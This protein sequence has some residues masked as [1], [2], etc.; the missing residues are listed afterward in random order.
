MHG[1]ITSLRFI[2]SDSIL[3]PRTF[4]LA[5][6][7]CRGLFIKFDGVAAT[8]QTP[9]MADFGVIDLNCP[10]PIGHID[11]AELHKV[12]SLTYGV[13]FSSF[14]TGA[15]SFAAFYIPF[16]N[17]LD[18]H[19]HNCFLL[20]KDYYMYI[21]AL[22]NLTKW[23]SCNVF[24]YA[25]IVE[26]GT[27]KYTPLIYSKV[28]GLQT[29]TKIYMDDRNIN[30]IA[31]SKPPTAP[32]GKIVLNRDGSM[33][34]DA[35]WQSSEILTNMLAEIE[36]GTQNMIL[37]KPYKDQTE[38]VGHYYELEITGCTAQQEFKFMVFSMLF[39]PQKSALAI[40]SI[41][42]Q[43]QRRFRQAGIMASV[44]TILP[45][46]GTY[47]PAFPGLSTNPDLAPARRPSFSQAYPPKPKIG[48]GFFADTETAI[49]E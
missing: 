15:A 4:H 26:I 3:S 1:D 31:A 22:L 2:A 32:T 8:G 25:N 12:N 29:N 43:V 13:A 35:D 40:Y 44:Y 33:I 38:A 47:G 48:K 42:P 6:Y 11:L 28:E 37:L 41:L 18:L 19:D 27:Q 21:P 39:E 45:P 16:Y 30:L 14:N 36:S 9:S 7:L 17:P 20:S 49:L 10:G 23:A 24:I 46:E 5:N 34:H